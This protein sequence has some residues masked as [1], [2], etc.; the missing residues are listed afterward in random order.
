MQY[1]RH[2]K[3]RE[4]FQRIDANPQNHL[5]IHYSC[6][7]FYGLND[8]HSPRITSIA[9]YDFSTGQTDSFSIHKMAE[10][11]HV[12]M[13]DIEGRYDDLERAMLDE[14]FVYAK[15]HPMFY[16]VHWNMRDI[17]YGFKAIEHRYAVLGGNPYRIPDD[18]KIDLAR[19]LLDCYGAGY[20]EHPRMEKLLKQND[21]EVKDYLSGPKEAEAFAKHEYVKL[22][23]STLRKVDLFANIL[24]RAIDNTLVVKSKWTEIY[25]ISVQG[26]LNF[27]KETWWI[28]IIWTLV[29]MFLGALIGEFVSG[30]FK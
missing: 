29:S 27:C 26:F 15:E 25:G 21:I 14:F 24:K 17:N 23:M 7:S 10:R 20:T 11:Q 16:W 3:A 28:Q 4:V 30:W 1:A 12:A 2:K 18:H 19:L 9:V 13:S 8:G 5:I 6:E 22:H